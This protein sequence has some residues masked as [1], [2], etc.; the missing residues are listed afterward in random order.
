MNFSKF[1]VRLRLSY[2]RIFEISDKR[3]SKQAETTAALLS[4]SI[5]SVLWLTAE[6]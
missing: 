6:K 4:V 5:L 3:I 2:E 1:K